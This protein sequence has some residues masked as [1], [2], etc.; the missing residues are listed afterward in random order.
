MLKVILIFILSLSLKAQSLNFN[1]GKTLK[2]DDLK[3]NYKSHRISVYNYHIKRSEIYNG[4][5]FKEIL[6]DVYGDESRNYFGIKVTTRDKYSPIIEMYKFQERRPYL[7]FK[8]ADQEPFTTIKYY[9]DKVVD[10]GPYYLIWEEDYKKDAARRRDH[11]PYKI[12]GFTLVNEPPRSLRPGKNAAKD[13]H[14]GYKNFLKQCISCHQLNGFGGSKGGELLSSGIIKKRT[15]DYLMK[16]ID[17]PRKVDPKSTMDPFPTKID[18]RKK[19]IKDIVQYL[20]F[21]QVES[22]KPPKRKHSIDDLNKVLDSSK[23]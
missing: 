12:T 3:K 11:W 21:L 23:K 8:R 7:A 2:F 1:N 15:D 16:F 14:W 18:I 10:L 17:N 5:D 6:R 4:F 20:R 19:R 13:L 9:A 22:E